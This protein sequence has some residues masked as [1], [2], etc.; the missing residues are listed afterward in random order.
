[1]NKDQAVGTIIFL[2][3]VLAAILYIATLFFPSWPKLLGIQ[4]PE[5]SV[6]FWAVATPVLLA[7][8]ALMGIGAWIGLTMAKTPPPKP[9][10]K[11]TTEIEE[12]P[13]A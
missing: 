8:I 4:L 9:I 10:E 5:N 7:F 3:C 12:K 11:I 13:E 6:Q 2:L 1:L